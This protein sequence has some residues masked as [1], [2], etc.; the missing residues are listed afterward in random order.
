MMARLKIYFEFI[1][2]SLGFKEKLPV[3]TADIDWADFY[4]FAQKQSL[5]G[6]VFDGIARLPKELA[7]GADLLMRWMGGS[8]A[9]RRHN[10]IM[11]RASE[12][13]F[14]KIRKM[15][16]RCC[17]LKGQGNAIAY[18]NPYSRTAGDVDVWVLS[19]NRQ[20]LRQVAL[21]LADSPEEVSREIV[22]HIELSRKG[23]AVELHPTPMMFN[24]PI[25]NRR[26]QRW[27]G[28]NADLQCSNVVDLPDGMG[29]MAIPTATFNAIYQLSHL[30]HHFFYEGV[31]LRQVIDY[32][33]VMD[34]LDSLVPDTLRRDLRHLGLWNF[35][36]AVMYVLHEVLGLAES[37]MIVPVDV[38]RGKLLL[39][40]I[41]AGGNFGQYGSRRHF[42]RGTVG[43]NIQRIL[44]DLRL[45]RYYPAEA[46]AEP[47]FRVWHFC[48]RQRNK[49]RQWER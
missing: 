39:D 25:L 19:G 36:G 14:S 9:I 42:G 20:K 15:G 1:Q 32:Y 16:L 11:Y 43:H 17:I 45:V 48:W 33:W 8:V 30:Y 44:R 22:Q 12:N 37:K 26:M 23:V 7:P 18:P 46:L 31:G 27:F 47:F 21:D 40:E 28:R 6:V 29:R 49:V 3:M 2:Y 41:L 10:A 4:R 13:V 5:L 24:N 34:R 38:W 35:A